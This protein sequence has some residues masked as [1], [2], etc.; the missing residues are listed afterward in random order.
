M[1]DYKDPTLSPE[2]RARDLLSQM[3]LPEK[4]GQLNEIPLSRHELADIESEIRTG[5]VGS[6]IYATSALAGDEE[7][8]C[9]NLEDRQ[10]C[11]RIAVAVSYTHLDVYKRQE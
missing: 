2:V 11:Q 6:L 5:R 9:G 7:Q 4:I 3:T 1:P 10:R 8:F